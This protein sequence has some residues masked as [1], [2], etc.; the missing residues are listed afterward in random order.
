M[1]TLERILLGPAPLAFVMTLVLLGAT[2]AGAQ[3]EDPGDRYTLAGKAI[4]PKISQ[5]TTWGIVDAVSSRVDTVG[6]LQATMERLESSGIVQ[7]GLPKLSHRKLISY[8]G[9]PLLI[10]EFG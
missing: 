8:D 7:Y 3:E 1:T 10:G 9:A 2:A 6:S 5:A 4:A